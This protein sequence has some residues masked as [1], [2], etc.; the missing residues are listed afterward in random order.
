[1]RRCRLSTYCLTLE[2]KR[3]ETVKRLEVEVTKL[4]T[5]LMN[6]VPK[7]LTQVAKIMGRLPGFINSVATFL[8]RMVDQ[9]LDVTQYYWDEKTKLINDLA[10]NYNTEL[11]DEDDLYLQVK[12]EVAI[13]ESGVDDVSL[14]EANRNVGKLKGIM[15]LLQ[16]A[17][18]L[19]KGAPDSLIK[20]QVDPIVETIISL[21]QK[22][23]K[24]LNALFSSI[25]QM[26]NKMT[27]MSF[28]LNE[29]LKALDEMTKDDEAVHDTMDMTDA[30]VNV[31]KWGNDMIK[32][33]KMNEWPIK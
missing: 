25:P 3:G 20:I 33:G 14:A 5:E 10:K 23:V 19:L 8:V 2:K 9:F 11:E 16:V 13:R 32:N 22:L 12:C 27:D 6:V 17:W 18:D 30:A 21:P 1:M 29:I 4:I 26:M 7:F 31:I 28:W 24:A 15:Q